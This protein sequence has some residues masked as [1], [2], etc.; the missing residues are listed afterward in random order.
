MIRLIKRVI[1]GDKE[2]KIVVEIKDS[3]QLKVEDKIVRKYASLD[4]C[5][6]ENGMF[7]FL[8]EGVYD[9]AD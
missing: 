7:E 1:E 9:D 2:V 3:P 6:L 8:P 4:E 5:L